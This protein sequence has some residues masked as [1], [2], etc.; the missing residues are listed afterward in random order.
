MTVSVISNYLGAQVLLKHITSVPTWLSLHISDPTVLGL[1]ASEV[2][3]GGYARQPLAW[4]V[5][6]N[7][8][9]ANTNATQHADLPACTVTDLGVWDALSGGNFLA[10]IH[11]VTPIAVPA[12]GH[13]LVAVGDLAL[14][15]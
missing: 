2:A 15:L 5:P 9:T 6:S 8:A 4:S 7:K 13:F 3:G 11:L 1:S 10:S 12:S 14:Q